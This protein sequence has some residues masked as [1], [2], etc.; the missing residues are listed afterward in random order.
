M[1]AVERLRKKIVALSHA[2]L[3][4]M[5]DQI[6]TGTPIPGWARGKAL[7]YVLLRAFQ[8]EGAKVTWPYDVRMKNGPKISIEQLDGAIHWNGQSCLVEAK[9]NADKID[10][11]PI[12]KLRSILAR[13]PSSCFGMVFSRAGYTQSAQILSDHLSPQTILLW[14]G[15]EIK[16]CFAK[17]NRFL[18]GLEAKLHWAVEHG[19]PVFDITVG[20]P[21]P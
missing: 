3:A 2:D 8:L 19:T 5:Y 6:E 12:A 18:I 14:E 7:E 10:F 9:D 4:K 13:R 21:W 20:I 15:N 1:T 11:V 17:P 16:H